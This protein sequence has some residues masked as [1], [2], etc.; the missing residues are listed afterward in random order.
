M[1]SCAREKPA[2]EGPGRWNVMIPEG[3][4]CTCLKCIQ[5]VKRKPPAVSTILSRILILTSQLLGGAN[6]LLREPVKTGG[7][8]GNM[9]ALVV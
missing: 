9:E 6:F 8:P 2:W 3:M 5:D 1:N 7:A 4:P